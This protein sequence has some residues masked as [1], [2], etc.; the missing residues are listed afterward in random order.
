MIS[1]IRVHFETLEIIISIFKKF[2]NQWNSNLVIA[3]NSQI[4]K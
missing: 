3:K 1:Y 2:D 4:M